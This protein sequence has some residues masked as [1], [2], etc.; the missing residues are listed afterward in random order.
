MSVSLVAEGLPT[1]LGA[2]TAQV[3]DRVGVIEY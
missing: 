1:L 2:E 3:A